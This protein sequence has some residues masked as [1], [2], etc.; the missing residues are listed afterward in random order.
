M[1]I[2]NKKRECELGPIRP[3]SESAS[4]LIR[5]TRNCPWNKCA[6]CPVYKTTKFSKR[7]EEDVI[8][9]IDILADAADR[10]RSHAALAGEQVQI[11]SQMCLDIVRDPSTSDDEKRVAFWLRRG[12]EHVFLQHADSLAIP[13]HRVGRILDRMSTC[14]MNR[15]V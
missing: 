2:N 14:A 15:C 6:F 12:G 4:L 3:P 7:S 5:V 11:S 9:D 1:A 13:P 10:V 8:Q